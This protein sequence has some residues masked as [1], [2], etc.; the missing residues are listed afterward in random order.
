MRSLRMPSTSTPECT[1]IDI[2]ILTYYRV[3]GLPRLD[4]D[5]LGCCRVRRRIAA[6]SC[7]MLA[8]AL[9]VEVQCRCCQMVWQPSTVVG[10]PLST[11][12]ARRKLGHFTD[13]SCVAA[14]ACTASSCMRAA[15][16]H[17][18]CCDKGCHHIN[19]DNGERGLLRVVFDLIPDP[20]T[21]L[22]S[23]AASWSE[24]QLT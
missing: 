4:Q 12:M 17:A 23:I 14:S 21:L 8:L 16:D 1:S 5:I 3:Y 13:C 9:T 11:S 10:H 24:D 19:L 22:A 6:W 18:F 15:H 20:R 7:A 2:R